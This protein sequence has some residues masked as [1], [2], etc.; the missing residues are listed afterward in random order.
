MATP[1]ALAQIGQQQS[2]LRE[3]TA[4]NCDCAVEVSDTAAAPNRCGICLMHVF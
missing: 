2:L 1:D 4:I 3:G